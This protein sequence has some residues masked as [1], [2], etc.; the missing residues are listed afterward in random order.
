MT[1]KLILA[2]TLALAG[3]TLPAAAGGFGG[4]ALDIPHLTFPAKA[5]ADAPAPK[6]TE[7]VTRAC[8]PN[9]CAQPLAK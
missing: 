1:R 3:T 7:T 4:V 5:Q 6:P 9:A 2:A 8:T